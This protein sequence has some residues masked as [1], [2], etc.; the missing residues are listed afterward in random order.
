MR[1]RKL[2]TLSVGAALALSATACRDDSG[3]DD[4]PAKSAQTSC[5]TP[6]SPE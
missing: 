3:A 6:V 1:P 2:A 4:V 5:I